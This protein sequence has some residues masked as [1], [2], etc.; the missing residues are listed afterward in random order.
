[1]ELR[2]LIIRSSQKIRFNYKKL[3][4]SGKSINKRKF[5]SKQC[6]H[7]WQFINKKFKS[8]NNKNIIIKNDTYSG[9]VILL[10]ASDTLGFEDDPYMGWNIFTGDVK[11]FKIQSDH[12]GMMVSPIAA[13]QIA[14]I[15]NSE[16]S[17]MK[18]ER[19]TKI[20]I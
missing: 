17:Q 8:S 7:A 3:F 1:M 4:V 12:I 14:G 19:E 16:L 18:I 6:A 11:K 5:I 2:S 9:K 15:L 10:E 20:V 13:K